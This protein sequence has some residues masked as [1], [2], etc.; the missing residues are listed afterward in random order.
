[1]RRNVYKFTV[2]R[3]IEVNDIPLVA[4]PLGTAQAVCFTLFGNTFN[5]INSGLVLSTFEELT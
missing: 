1:M 2:G 5:A 3:G 4:E